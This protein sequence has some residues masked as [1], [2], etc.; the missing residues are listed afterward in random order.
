MECYGN[1]LWNHMG[2]PPES[3]GTPSECL[4]EFRASSSRIQGE[5]F[6]SPGSIKE[7]FS[8]K[9]GGQILWNLFRNRLEFLQ[10]AMWN[11][12]EI[13]IQTQAGLPIKRESL[14]KAS[15]KSWYG[16]GR[17]PDV[18]TAMTLISMILL[19]MSVMSALTWPVVVIKMCC[20][21]LA[22]IKPIGINSIDIN[23]VGLKHIFIYKACSYAY[24]YM[25]M[26]C[27]LYRKGAPAARGL[28]VPLLVLISLY[29]W[30]LVPNSIQNMRYNMSSTKS[31]I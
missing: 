12:L 14:C 27:V 3:K 31:N 29:S 5:P 19:S 8:R 18:A 13:T 1:P 4:C 11:P 10:T 2:S 20:I 17:R 15:D 6:A 30:L 7:D 9:V 24:L 22:D 23:H 28:L 26:R 25:C 16:H 21:C